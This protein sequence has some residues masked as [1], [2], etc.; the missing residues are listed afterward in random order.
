MDKK[1]VKKLVSTVDGWLSTREG[2][3]LYTLAN[4]CKGKGAIVE[5]GSWKGKSTIW[6]ANGSKLAGNSKIHAIDPHVG[7]SEHNTP[8]QQ[9]WTFDQFKANIEKAGVADHIVPLIM[10]SEK[11]AQDF[12]KPVELIFIDGAH[13][14]EYVKQDF[15]L[16]FP[17]VI[18]GGVMAFHDTVGW[19]GPKKVVKDLVYNSKHFKKAWFVDSITYAQKVDKNSGLDR[20]KNKG[21]LLLKDSLETSKNLIPKK[22]RTFVK[23]TILKR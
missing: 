9:V 21:A 10:T 14:Y 17:K 8:E 16:W 22:I 15:E 3:L 12:D 4:K 19:D 5:I 23:K 11:A 2:K 6:L 1:S 7:S 20:L 13:E 18:P